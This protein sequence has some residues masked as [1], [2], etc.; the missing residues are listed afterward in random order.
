MS[1]HHSRQQ[2]LSSFSS[3]RTFQSSFLELDLAIDS[4]SRS[5]DWGG[6]GR[7][8]F[9]EDDSSG[10]SGN[11]LIHQGSPPTVDVVGEAFTAPS[12]ERPETSF[13]GPHDDVGPIHAILIGIL[14]LISLVTTD[15]RS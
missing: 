14:T 12:A 4:E 9:L 11:V 1:E 3:H 13:P 7:S 15:R 2:V 10:G 6:P 8:G 5:T